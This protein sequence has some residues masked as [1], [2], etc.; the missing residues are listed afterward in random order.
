VAECRALGLNVHNSSISDFLQ[1]LGPEIRYDIIILSHVL[2]HLLEPDKY[3]RRFQE[4]LNP[5]GLLVVAV[6]ANDSIN[7]KVFGRYWGWWQVPVH[8]NHFNNRGMVCL[9]ERAGFKVEKLLRHGGDSLMIVLN[10]INLL[11]VGE[12][13]GPMSA[14]RKHLLSAFSVFLRY[15]YRI[16]D[17][18]LVA[19]LRSEPSAG[20]A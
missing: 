7:A 20:A 3:L 5:G 10:F 6:P 19:I 14:T 1:G 2:E 12:S 9:A 4:I 18:E 15:W 16:G 13:L 8:I 17:E 11:G